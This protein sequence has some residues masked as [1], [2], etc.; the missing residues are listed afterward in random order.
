MYCSARR[1]RRRKNGRQLRMCLFD[2]PPKFSCQDTIRRFDQGERQHQGDGEFSTGSQACPKALPRRETSHRELRSQDTAY[3]RRRHRLT[4]SLVDRYLGCCEGK[5]NKPTSRPC[6]ANPGDGQAMSEKT[7]SASA[8]THAEPA[9]GG[10][11]RHPCP[12]FLGS[13]AARRP[14]SATRRPALIRG[15][16]GIP[17]QAADRP[18]GD[19]TNAEADPRGRRRP[20]R[21][22]RAGLDLDRRGKSPARLRVQGG[23]APLSRRGRRARPAQGG[24]G[25]H[26][27]IDTFLRGPGQRSSGTRRASLL[28]RAEL[29]RAA[30]RA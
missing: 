26:L 8:Q 7:S 17:A 3:P 20:A 15:S 24:P 10:G 29:L 9:A 23:I 2:Q 13:N 16:L 12:P 21:A 27:A 18:P 25:R 22:G 5:T 19:I 28:L 30:L 4:G 14:C 1:P 6:E 11:P